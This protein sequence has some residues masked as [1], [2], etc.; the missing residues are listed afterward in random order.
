MTIDYAAM[1]EEHG[2]PLLV[3]DCDRLREQVAS[4]QAAMPNV[5]LHYAAK[6]LNHPDVIDTLAD[7]GLGFDVASRTELDAVR[8]AF[9]PPRDV[10]HSHPIKTREEI[11]A[12][13]RMGCTTFVVDNPAEIDK[14]SEVRH[15]IGL[16]L[17]VR[18]A[19]QAARVQLS[20]KFGCAP[21]EV[22]ELLE[23]ADRLGIHVKGLS[24]HIGS[25]ARDSQ[26]S[27][28]A[29]R[30]CLN[31]INARSARNQPMR[32]LD[33]GGG[34]PTGPD[35]AGEIQ[36]WCAPIR[37]AL[38]MAPASLQVLAEPGRFLVAPAV[39]GVT[40]VVGK[41][42]RNEQPWYYIDDGVYGSFSGLLF[43]HGQYPI[44][45]LKQTESAPS[46]ASVLAGPTCDGIDIV[47]E[48]IELPELALGDVLIAE[49]MGAYT[50]ASATH[51][52]GLTP[53]KIVSQN[54]PSKR[55]NVRAIGSR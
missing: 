26:A 29:I 47:A 25:Q 28:D 38:T 24:F 21:I 33:I 31:W 23:H 1:A 30:Q 17:R 43:D 51:F 41:A 45:P 50:A 34:F 9:V 3:L 20:N 27:A 10:I 44:A 46:V 18:F 8:Q 55:L 48:N 36:A 13:L 37:E 15:R 12:A 42:I 16:L 22:P 53:A 5:R 52:N 11:Y 35:A 54:A 40:R 19:D 2:S 7:L 4:L 39:T 14:F 32:I 6:A 49:N